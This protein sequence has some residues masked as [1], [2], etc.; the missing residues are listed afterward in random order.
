ML[1]I[2]DNISQMVVSPLVGYV[3]LRYNRSRIIA[4]GE[5]VVAM[6]CFVFAVPYFIYGPGVHLLHDDVTLAKNET[7]YQVCP[8]DAV[9]HD[10]SVGRAHNTVWPA[11]IILWVASFIQVRFRSTF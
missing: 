7:D 9:D 3:A 1:L 10:C 11:V 6:G 2:A 8:A 5:S 4:I